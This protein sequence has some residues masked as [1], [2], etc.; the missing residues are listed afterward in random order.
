VNT[1]HKINPPSIILEP[2]LLA[3]KKTPP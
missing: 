3:K 1:A 2:I